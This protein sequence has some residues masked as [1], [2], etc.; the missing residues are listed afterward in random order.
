MQRPTGVTVLAILQFIST[1]C[2]VLAGLGVM[3]GMGVV[4]AMLAQQ[5][6]AGGVGVGALAGMG[7]ALGVIVLFFAVLQ[8]VVA[9]GM[10]TLKNW[11]RII[12]IVC[13]GLGAAFLALGLLG[14]LAH[15]NLFGLIWGAFWMGIY[16]LIIW[17]LM[18]PNVVQAFQSGGTMAAGAGR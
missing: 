3:L 6:K 1:G 9:W 2:M 18:Q 4:G 8:G 12:N 13:T 14:S 7:A 16:G 10:W 17:Y 5:G 11:A 15:F